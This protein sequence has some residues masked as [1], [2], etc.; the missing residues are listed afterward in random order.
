MSIVKRVQRERRRGEKFLLLTFSHLDPRSGKQQQQ[1]RQS[2]GYIQ[3]GR[4]T[5]RSKSN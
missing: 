3:A 1:Q 5:R 4:H 2:S